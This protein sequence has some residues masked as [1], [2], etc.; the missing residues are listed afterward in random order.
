MASKILSSLRA[1]F[2]NATSD[3]AIE[4][5]TIFDNHSRI[6]ISAGGRISWGDGEDPVDIYIERSLSGSIDVS[7]LLNPTRL[8]VNNAYSF[9]NI[10]GVSGEV[11]ATDGTGNLYW[12]NMP[13]DNA[14]LQWVGL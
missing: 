2:F 4:A 11:I 5:S 13:A 12:S 3:T 14:I 8:S 10:D 9:A 7:G 1:R 6:L